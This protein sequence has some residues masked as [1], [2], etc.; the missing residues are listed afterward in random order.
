MV[1]QSCSFCCERPKHAQYGQAL[2][3]GSEPGA[4]YIYIFWGGEGCCACLGHV[5][6]QK[7]GGCLFFL[8]SLYV[9]LLS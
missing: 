1:Y 9:A 5:G 4:R 7:F 6:S 2:P 3:G 8:P